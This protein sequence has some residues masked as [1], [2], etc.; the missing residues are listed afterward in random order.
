ME[1]SRSMVVFFR[2]HIFKLN[3]NSSN[4]RYSVS[5]TTR[6]PRPGE[7]NGVDYHFV[8]RDAMKADIDKGE[9]LENAEFSGNLYGT[10]YVHFSFRIRDSA[11]FWDHN[12]FS[13]FVFEFIFVLFLYFFFL[14]INFIKYFNLI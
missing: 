1:F 14:I 6:K 12:F 13:I 4:S 10:R 11:F 3:K 9:F 7:K 2:P 5:H 8:E